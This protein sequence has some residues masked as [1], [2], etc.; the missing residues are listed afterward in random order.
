MTEAAPDVPYTLRI[1]GGVREIPRETWDAM[2]GEESSPFVEHTW[3]ELLEDTGCVG[4]GTG[5]LPTHL[6]LWRGPTL[7]AVAPSYL[8]GNSEGEFVFDW[9]WA[10][11]AQR[12][13]LPYYPKLI[14]A[15]PFTPATGDRVL[16]APGEDRARLTRVLADAG[17]A[18][19]REGRRVEAP[20]ALS[21]ARRDRGLAG[22]RVPAARGL[23]VPLGFATGSRRS[24]STSRAS[25][26]SSA[27]R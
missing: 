15:V 12:L 19:V 24:T 17:A 20:H 5:W 11:L 18:M 25:T 26:P 13:G 22:R 14:V 8:K 27:T 10:D 6:S 7:V 23:P 4:E 21:P 1:L 16:V 3:L 9:G 2:V